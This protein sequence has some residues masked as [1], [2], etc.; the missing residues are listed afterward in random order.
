MITKGMSWLRNG[1][2]SSRQKIRNKKKMKFLEDNRRKRL[3]AE[4]GERKGEDRNKWLWLG[5]LTDRPP[6]W[7]KAVIL[8][9][10]RDGEV[11]YTK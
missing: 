11:S 10:R 2:C 9:L 6:G 5:K 7:G 4:R 8:G 3:H 1:G